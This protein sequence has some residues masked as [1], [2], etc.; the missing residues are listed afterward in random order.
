MNFERNINR[1]VK[2]TCAVL[3][4]CFIISISSSYPIKEYSF[5]YSLSSVSYPNCNCVELHTSSSMLPGVH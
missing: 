1:V 2:E 4:H 3:W 5:P